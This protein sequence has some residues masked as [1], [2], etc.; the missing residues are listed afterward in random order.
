VIP[1]VQND[2]DNLDGWGH[3]AMGAEQEQPQPME[4]EEQQV[5]HQEEMIL[6]DQHLGPPLLDAGS[7]VNVSSSSSESSATFDTLSVAGPSC[8][9][10]DQAQSTLAEQQIDQSSLPLGEGLLNILQAY[11]SQDDSL[12]NITEEVAAGSSMLALSSQLLTSA[13]DDMFLPSDVNLASPNE[14]HL[15]LTL[16]RVQTYFS[17]VPEEHELAKKVSSHH[18]TV[19]RD[20]M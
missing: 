11:S 9:P 14:A 2:P 20:K 16:G 5:D 7:L 12:P 10:L 4:V 15:Q 8:G 13:D 6:E 18:R 1:A 19:G 3:W 17:P